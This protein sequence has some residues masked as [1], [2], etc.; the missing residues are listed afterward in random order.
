VTRPPYPP[1]PPYPPYPP[2][3]SPPPYPPFPA[4]PPVLIGGGPSG[5]AVSAP[6]AGSS[7]G[8]VQTPTTQPTGPTTEPGKPTRFPGDD[9][10]NPLSIYFNYGRYDVVDVTNEGLGQGQAAK[11]T[12]FVADAASSRAREIAVDGFASP[13]DNLPN[14]NLPLNRATAVKKRLDQLFANTS[15]KPTISARTTNVLSGDPSVWPSLRRA[16]IYITSRSS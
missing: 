1:N 9:K 16:D 13:E 12:K 4:Y 8:T 3:V 15:V 7:T 10:T 6:Y 2:H 11:L 5:A 14:S